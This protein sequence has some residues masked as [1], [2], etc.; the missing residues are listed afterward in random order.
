VDIYD[1][2]GNV[3]LSLGNDSLREANLRRANL[4]EANLSGANLFGANLSWANL[5]GANLFGANLFGAN[6]SWANL[7]GANLSEANLSGANLFGANLSEADLREADLREASL[8]GA[9]L[10]GA[11]VVNT[12][13][14]P[15]NVPSGAGPEF[16]SD[17]MMPTYVIGYRTRKAGHIAQYLD[18]RVYSADIFS[19]CT[20]TGCHP[21][22]YLWP[23]FT[24]ARRWSGTDEIISV[25]T[26]VGDVHQAGG[27]YR[28][29]WFEVIGSCDG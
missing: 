13:L 6:L 7:R 9:N 12:V 3:L 15:V 1:I 23:T 22:L 19:T 16:S 26:K 8:F 24:K 18:G 21:G 25:R 20:E 10:F 5:R 4:S 2:P 17:T 28:C 29:R 14:D 27:K 11:V